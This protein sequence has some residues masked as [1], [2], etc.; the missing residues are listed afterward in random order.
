LNYLVTRQCRRGQRLPWFQGFRPQ[1][2]RGAQT[3]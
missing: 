1:S 2:V 3:A